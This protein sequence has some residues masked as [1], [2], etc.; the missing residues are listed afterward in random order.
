MRA[1]LIKKTIALLLA[2]AASSSAL[3]QFV[4]IDANG[5]RQYSDR[6]PPASVPKNKILKEPGME[7]RNSRPSD[8]EPAVPAKDAAAAPKGPQTIAEKNADFIKRNND[9]A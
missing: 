8:P 1:L 7:L 9:Q 4:W 5:T 2:V 6:P 3:A